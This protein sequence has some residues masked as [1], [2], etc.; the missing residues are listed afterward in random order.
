M[1]KSS[2]NMNKFASSFGI[3][4]IAAYHLLSYLAWLV[5]Q[6]LSLSRYE[7][8]A[9]WSLPPVASCFD[10]HAGALAVNDYPLGTPTV[11]AAFADLAVL[12]P[13]AIAAAVGL[14]NREMYGLVCSWLVFGVHFYRALFI[15]WQAGTAGELTAAGAVP[16]AERAVVYANLA[17]SV[18]GA[19]FQSR[20]VDS[21]SVVTVATVDA[22]S[23]TTSSAEDT[24]LATTSSVT[25]AASA[26]TSSAADAASTTTSIAVDAASATTSMTADAASATS[27]LS[28]DVSSATTLSAVDTVSATALSDVEA[29]SVTTSSAVDAAP[30]TILS[31]VDAASVRTLSAMD[32]VSQSNEMRRY[33]GEMAV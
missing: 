10:E 9:S 22:A 13:L 23:A 17:F 31:A 1:N 29:G 11:A 3:K 8:L 18:W 12:L 19:W 24:A 15:F 25:D 4:L 33:N 30:I 32:A 28:M 21:S 2:T 16:I 20:Y 7:T 26:K 14:M 27:S 5:L 6:V